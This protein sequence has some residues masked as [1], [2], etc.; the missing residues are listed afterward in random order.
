MRKR[1]LQAPSRRPLNSLLCG[2]QMVHIVG[3]ELAEPF[4]LLLEFNT[5]E[6]KLVDIE[7]YLRG[8]VFRPVREDPDYFRL[9]EVDDELGTIVWPNGAD[10]DP[11]VLYGS[12]VPAWMEAELALAV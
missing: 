2:K 6:G 3:V 7:R 12:H 10:I 1:H 8:P 11:D 4:K 9:V 5:G